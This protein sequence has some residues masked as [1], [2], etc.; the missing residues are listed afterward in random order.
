MT[1]YHQRQNQDID[2][3]RAIRRCVLN[4]RAS[5]T[6]RQKWR[7]FKG[8]TDKSTIIVR[9]FSTSSLSP[10][11]Q[12]S[13]HTLVNKTKEG[14]IKVMDHL[15]LRESSRRLHP[16]TAK[17]IP[18]K[19]MSN[20]HQDRLHAGPQSTSQMPTYTGVFSDH[21][22]IKVKPKKDLESS[23]IIGKCIT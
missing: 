19:S 13:P 10:C 8:K 22:A 6:M 18:F 20:T 11:H 14:L 1:K 3:K 9:D 15:D 23:P 2:S 21:E 12:T 17:H 16:T 7:E 5:K 4:D